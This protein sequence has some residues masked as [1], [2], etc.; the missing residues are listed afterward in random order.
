M[1]FM[2][3][4]ELSIPTVHERK[5]RVRKRGLETPPPGRPS[6]RPRP[7]RDCRRDQAVRNQP[8]LA[9]TDRREFNNR[10][11]KIVDVVS[12]DEVEFS[13]YSGMQ[14]DKAARR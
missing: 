4:V 8:W 12:K 14:E 2:A 7:P 9:Q 11:A 1:C 6:R 10:M 13:G 5:W 3:I